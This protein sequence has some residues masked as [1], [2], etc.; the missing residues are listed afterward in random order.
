MYSK[1]PKATQVAAIGLIAST[2]TMDKVTGV[3]ISSNDEWN[4]DLLDDQTLLET[5]K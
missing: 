1:L 3:K 5:K 4:P 2:V